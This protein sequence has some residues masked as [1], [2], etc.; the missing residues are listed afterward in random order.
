[1]NKLLTI[2]VLGFFALVVLSVLGFFA[3]VGVVTPTRVTMGPAPTPTVLTRSVPAN[4]ATHDGVT[5][6]ASN[7]HQIN[8]G[9]YSRSPAGQQYIVVHIELTNQGTQSARYNA[10]DFQ[11]EDATDLV[12]H[13]ADMAATH[14]FPTALSRGSIVAGEILAGDIVFRVPATEHQFSLLW[15][16]SVPVAITE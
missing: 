15:T 12:R 13:D 2:I 5:V 9:A 11:L 16:P 6:T 4:A 10:L 8:G 14:I 1:M 7:L 3:L